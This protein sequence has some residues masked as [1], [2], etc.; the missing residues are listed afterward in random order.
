MIHMKSIVV[1]SL[2]LAACSSET[3]NFAETEAGAE[4][5]VGGAAGAAGAPAGGAAG[6][7][8]AVSGG[9]AGV[10]GV[11][12]D[13]SEG[14]ASIEADVDTCVLPPQTVGDCVVAVCNG[15]APILIGDFSD[16]PIDDGNPC[17]D[18][19]CVPGGP[20]GLPKVEHSKKVAGAA[21]NDGGVCNSS[22]F[23][24]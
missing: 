9:A 14:E 1:L 3:I 13:A 22:G 8:G 18:D 16:V 15:D 23:C 7:A 21:C 2:L 12:Q 19:V 4:T 6:A 24:S 20:F 17:T 5:T 10:A 11:G